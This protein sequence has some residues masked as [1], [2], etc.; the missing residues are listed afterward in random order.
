MLNVR[1][2]MFRRSGAGAPV[3]VFHSLA[4]GVPE[5][6]GVVGEVAA[7][8]AAGFHG[9]AVGPFEAETLEKSGRLF[10]LAGVEGEGG[11]DA[12]I[13]SRRKLVVV[14]GDPEFLLRA[15]EADPDE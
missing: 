6:E 5:E 15:A 14:T 3:S 4:E 11:S 7:E 2:S 10:H 9:Q 8:E 12:E 13:N 1:C